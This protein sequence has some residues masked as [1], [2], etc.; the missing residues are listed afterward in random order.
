MN[1]WL[2]D[3]GRAYPARRCDHPARGEAHARRRVVD[4]GFSPGHGALGPRAWQPTSAGVLSLDG[5]WAFRLLASPR[6]PAAFADPSF[7]DRGWETLPVPSHW[8]LH[9]HG[10]P[11]Y[12]N[13][14]YP[15]PFDPPFVP[16]ENPTG[17][18][19]CRF[20]LPPGWP[21]GAALLRFGGAD[22]HL[23]AWLNGVELG[24]A[25]GS[26]LVH[27]FEVGGLLR[28][29]GENVL[30]VRVSQW[31]AGSY[32]EDQDMWWLSGLFRG[33][34]LLARPPG[35][36]GDVFVHAAA[37]GTLRVDADAPARLL[38]P[39]LGVDAVAGESVE[40]GPVEAWSAEVP[41]LYHARLRAESET[42]ALR[43]GFRTVAVED[44]ELRVNGRRVLLRGVNRH[45]WDP[46]RGRA[47]GVGTM[48]R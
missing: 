11:A 32:L 13:V 43:I 19:R 8:Q 3:T 6:E 18:Y 14:A 28:R 47:I 37:D 15:F 21:G 30:A 36:V 27:E 9:G 10:A 22:S 29:D 34:D 42:L 12:T 5:R 16:D 1:R 45:D 35:C 38:V 20:A 44:G 48:R 23:R 41:R 17:E 39:E 2:M 26:R 40:A 46:E 7:D 4:G 24:W 31:S 25:C 33:V